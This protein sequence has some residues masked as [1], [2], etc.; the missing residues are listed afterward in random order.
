MNE[1]RII[2]HDPLYGS[3]LAQV[4]LRPVHLLWCAEMLLISLLFGMLTYLHG[5]SIAHIYLHIMIVP[6]CRYDCDILIYGRTSTFSA[7]GGIT[8][9]CTWIHRREDTR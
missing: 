2:I 5:K 7:D 1:A 6:S 3:S 4:I 9:T 8:I